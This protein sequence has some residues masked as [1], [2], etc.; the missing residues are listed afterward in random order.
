MK[1]YFYLLFLPMMFGF[2]ATNAQDF[3][4]HTDT[5]KILMQNYLVEAHNDATN[6]TSGDIKISWKVYANNLPQDWIDSAQFGICDNNLCYYNEILDGN[7]RTSFDVS[8]LGLM[9]FKTQVS[10]ESIGVVSTGT[11]YVAVELTHGTTVDTAVFQF[12]RW[13]TNVSN[14]N[15]NLNKVSLYPNPARSELNVTYDKEAGVKSI[16]I[17]NLVGKQV[18]K[19]KVGGSSAKLDIENVPSGVYFVRLMDNTGRVMATR[20]FTHQ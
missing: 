16:A 9:A 2:S 10:G 3:T 1:K 7:P 15:G 4:M 5:V 8:A 20:R 13:A 11:Y 18:V 12:S 14:V 17:Y 6:T 19:Y